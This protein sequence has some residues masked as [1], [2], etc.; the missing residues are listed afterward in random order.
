MPEFP[1]AHGPWTILSSRLVHRD[2]WVTVTLDDRGVNS[3]VT[4]FTVVLSG[5][6]IPL[7]LYP[8]WLHRA[9][10]IQPFAG[11]VDIPFRIYSG[12]LAGRAAWAGIGLQAF[13]TLA[14]VVG[15]R[16]WIERVMRRL[17]VQGG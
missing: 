14:F 1:R 16:V 6:L 4:P 17:E 8:D 5:N 11:V 7:V 3:M 12:H 10:F 9:L 2:P 13:W 15:G